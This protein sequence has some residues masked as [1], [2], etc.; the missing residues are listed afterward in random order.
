MIVYHVDQT[1]NGD[2]GKYP[3]NETK[4]EQKQTNKEF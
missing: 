4:N 1:L 3:F 2:L